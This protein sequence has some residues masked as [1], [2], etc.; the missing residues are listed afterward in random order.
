[1]PGRH[2]LAQGL[3]A[4]RAVVLLLLHPDAT[5]DLERLVAQ[6]VTVLEQQQGLALQVFHADPLVVREPVAG[7]HRQR[8][9]LF[10]ERLGLESVERHGQREDAHV[11]LAGT[12]LLEQR[13][14]LV[15]V[16]HQLEPG[17]FA[18]Q[19]A[20]DV[21]QQV[22]PDGGDQRKPERSGQRV[23]IRPCQLYD[24][25]GLEQQPTC[26]LDDPLAGLGQRDA[27]RLA[28]DE[29]HTEVLLELSDLCRQCRLA[30]VAALG[31]H[32]RSAA[33][34]PVRRDSGGHAGS[35]VKHSPRLWT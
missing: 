34:R 18:L 29:Q 27:P 26:P 22:R 13:R 35:C 20:H 3:E 21:R 24:R 30:D 33:R 5:A 17:Q 7:G 14:R 32:G 9:W 12:Q 10:V 8:E 1:M 31:A 28:L 11:D 23:A 6:A 16:Q 2:H 4:G 25:I 15:L 19:A